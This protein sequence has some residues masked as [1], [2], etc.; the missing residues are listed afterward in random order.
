MQ[1]A[2]EPRP[3]RQHL[4]SEPA[5]A[6]AVG[7]DTDPAPGFL[8]DADQVIPIQNILH[9][10]NVELSRPVQEDRAAAHDLLPHDA[11][12]TNVAEPFCLPHGF[13]LARAV[14]FQLRPIWHRLHRL[15]DRLS[16]PVN[17]ARLSDA[18][19]KVQRGQV[20]PQV[21]VVVHGRRPFGLH[22]PQVIIVRLLALA[23]YGL[24]RLGQRVKRVSQRFGLH[25]QRRSASDP[26]AQGCHAVV[27][28]SWW[29]ALW[30]DCLA[31]QRLVSYRIRL[32]STPFRAVHY[33]TPHET[34]GLPQ[35]PPCLAAK[36][37]KPSAPCAASLRHSLPMPLASVRPPLLNTN[38]GSATCAPIP[39]ASSAKRWASR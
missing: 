10:F 26:D 24:M 37:S 31:P 7:A 27:L 29:P 28:Q 6:R 33:R 3:S 11:N 25:Q 8:D 36:N 13:L 5:K 39:S 14:I 18:P 19:L 12:A 17:L 2:C 35:C 30:R 22:Q 34:K 32:L 4:H 9:V 38:A 1:A 23:G 21:I 16:K 15:L 20:R